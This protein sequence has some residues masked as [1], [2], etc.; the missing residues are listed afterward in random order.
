MAIPFHIAPDDIRCS[1]LMA[2]RDYYREYVIDPIE[3]RLDWLK[4][5]GFRSWPWLTE[6]RQRAEAE[7]AEAQKVIRGIETEIRSMGKDADVLE[8]LHLDE[9]YRP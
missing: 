5:F 9:N 2:R 6:E 3:R 4:E 8:G 1:H 7:I